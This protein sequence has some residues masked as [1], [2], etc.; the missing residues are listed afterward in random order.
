M[1]T[2]FA[3]ERHFSEQIAAI[4][5]MIIGPDGRVG[6]IHVPLEDALVPNSSTIEHALIVVELE[7][8]DGTAVGGYCFADHATA[9]LHGSQ[10]N[11]M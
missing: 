5:F 1:C 11:H 8:V 9:S 4:L 7:L 10:A 3:L 6:V 2:H